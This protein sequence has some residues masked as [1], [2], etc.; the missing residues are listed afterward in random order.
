MTLIEQLHAACRSWPYFSTEVG[1]YCWRARVVDWLHQCERRLQPA[2]SED[3]EPNQA[4]GRQQTA[5]GNTP[6][7][8]QQ[9]QTRPKRKAAAGAAAATVACAAAC[10]AKDSNYYP[11]TD[12]DNEGLPQQQPKAR[13]VAARKSSTPTAAAAAAAAAP[14]DCRCH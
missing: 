8:H 3:Q 12:D 14:S 6:K 1:W 13:E 10:K 2:P 9:R 4:P 11:T 5:P 7:L